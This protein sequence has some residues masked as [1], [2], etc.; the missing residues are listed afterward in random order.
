LETSHASAVRIASRFLEATSKRNA[1]IIATGNWGDKRVLLKNRDRNYNPKVSIVRE[2]L[3]G[4]EVAYMTDEVTDWNE[5][6]NEHGIGIVNSALSVG[7]DEAEKKLVSI[8]KKSKD[9]VRILEALSCKTLAEAI[10]SAKNSHGGIKGHTFISSPDGVVAIEQTSKHECKVKTLDPDSIYVRTNHGIEYEDAGYTEGKKYIS[11]I[12][13]RNKAKEI[14]KD[15]KSPEGV[16]PALMAG[17]SKD[18]HDPNSVIRDTKDMSTTSQT[19]LNL[20]DL[21]L[22]LYVIPKKSTYEGLTNK[23]P[24]GQK[25][26]I[27]VRVFSYLDDGSEVVELDPETGKKKADPKKVASQFLGDNILVFSYGSNNPFI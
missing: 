8:G 17:R 7:R 18:R 27:K 12:A 19:I 23:L 13:R 25:P 11:S 3:E 14:L 15:V 4:V 1:C 22:I 5:G 9:G 24:K 26:K 2:V 10:K 6:L 20:T 16:A 21:E